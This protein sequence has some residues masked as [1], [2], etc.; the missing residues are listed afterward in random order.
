MEPKLSASSI[1][2]IAIFSA[3]GMTAAAVTVALLKT[4]ATYLAS[5]IG[6]GK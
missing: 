6:K 1:G 4:G 2:Y 5:N 3:I